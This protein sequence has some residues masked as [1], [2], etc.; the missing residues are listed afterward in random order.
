MVGGKLI[1]PVSGRVPISPEAWK[2]HEEPPDNNEAQS[3]PVYLSENKKT[4]KGW[5]FQYAN[6]YN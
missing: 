6:K 4:G 5:K 3:L 1:L 2:D